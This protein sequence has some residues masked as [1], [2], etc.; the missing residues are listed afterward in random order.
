MCK[1]Y[2]SR[3]CT[4]SLETM[5]GNAGAC[6]LV[7]TVSLIV[8]YGGSVSVLSV[9]VLSTDSIG[10]VRMVFSTTA[11]TTAKIKSPNIAEMKM[12]IHV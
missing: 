2:V 1:E 10:C 9:L 11:T 7:T 8:S 4:K 12:I 5:F 3:G 6:G